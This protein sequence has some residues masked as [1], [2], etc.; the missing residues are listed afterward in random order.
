MALENIWLEFSLSGHTAQT[1]I[2]CVHWIGVAKG[3]ASK[4][5]LVILIWNHLKQLGVNTGNKS[6]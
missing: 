1:L 4:N 2:V 6:C 5:V 3:G